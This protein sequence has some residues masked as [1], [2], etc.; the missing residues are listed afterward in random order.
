[1]DLL[2]NKSRYSKAGAG[3]QQWT[4]AG[5]DMDAARQW[6]QRTCLLGQA[7]GNKDLKPGD[8]TARPGVLHSPSTQ[9]NVYAMPNRLPSKRNQ[10]AKVSIRDRP[11][12]AELSE[13]LPLYFP[14]LAM[15]NLNCTHLYVATNQCANFLFCQIKTFLRS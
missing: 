9:H 11:L 4:G 6:D 10:R 2:R 14:D 1:M 7:S 8:L 15:S 5:D 3:S 12:S 13:H